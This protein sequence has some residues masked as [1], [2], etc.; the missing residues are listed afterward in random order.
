MVLRVLVDRGSSSD[1]IFWKTFKQMGVDQSL[2]SPR[3]TPVVAF[4]GALVYPVRTIILPVY[5]AD[6]KVVHMN[7]MIINTP[8]LM[9]VIMG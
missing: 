4:N 2:I 5:A 9:N 7:F 3:T 6:S 1:I 8:S